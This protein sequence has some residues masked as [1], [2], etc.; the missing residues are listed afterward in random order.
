MQNHQF[1]SYIASK[2]P[3]LASTW[4]NCLDSSDS[5]GSWTQ[6]EGLPPPPTVE[7]EQFSSNQLTAQ[8]TAVLSPHTKHWDNEES[9]DQN[10]G[11]Y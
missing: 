7:C 4:N 10:A 8:E 9:E 3:A 2:K 11:I 1:S 5:S 6:G